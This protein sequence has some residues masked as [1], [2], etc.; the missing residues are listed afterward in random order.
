MTDKQT[1]KK[2]IKASDLPRHRNDQQAESR[3]YFYFLKYSFQH[4]SAHLCAGNLS[5]AMGAR[6]QVGKGL[7]YW[8]A[9][10]CSLTTQFLESIPRT[11][12]GLKIPTHS[13]VFEG[14]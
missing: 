3:L 1:E 5:S 13:I 7:S 12:A 11:I 14:A 4:C 6:N 2:P 9:S 8:P 10:L